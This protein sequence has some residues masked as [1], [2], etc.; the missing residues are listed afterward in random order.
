MKLLVNM[1]GPAIGCIVGVGLTQMNPGVLAKIIIAVFAMFVL[2]TASNW[3]ANM[4]KKSDEGVGR[5][6]CVFLSVCIII[7]S[8]VIT[9]GVN[10]N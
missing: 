3:L 8:I 7:V 9:V 1:L 10:L 5:A 6:I 2:G 4:V